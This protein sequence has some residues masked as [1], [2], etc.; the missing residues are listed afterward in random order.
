VAAV[1]AL[2]RG[3][4][5]SLIAGVACGVAAGRVAER[6][7]WTA[8]TATAA[9]VSATARRASERL[10]G[11]LANA[12]SLAGGGSSSL[13]GTVLALGAPTGKGGDVAATAGVSRVASP[14]AAGFG[15]PSST[16]ATKE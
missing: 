11:G 9:T 14:R 15:I 7:K 10:T 4:A 12:G 1:L 16:V 8:T 5:V 6:A 2:E 13:E 3:A